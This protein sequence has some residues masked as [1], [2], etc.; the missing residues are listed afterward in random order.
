M[1]RRMIMGLRRFGAF[2]YD[3]VV[4]DDW[5][6]AMGVVAALA[7]TYGLSTATSFPSWWVMPAAVAFLLTLSLRRAIQPKRRGR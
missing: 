3:F 1:I 5:R 6:V 4:G 2:W 7:L